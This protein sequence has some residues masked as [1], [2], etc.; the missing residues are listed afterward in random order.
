MI[1]R[2]LLSTFKGINNILTNYIVE[3]Y[4]LKIFYNTLLTCNLKMFNS[5]NK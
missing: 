5:V 3:V 2:N 1:G 4:F